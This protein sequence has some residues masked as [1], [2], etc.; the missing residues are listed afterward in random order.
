MIMLLLPISG[1]II[2]SL[3]MLFIPLMSV[4]S[5]ESTEALNIF[6]I[7]FYSYYSYKLLKVRLDEDFYFFNLAS[8]LVF[9]VIPLLLLFISGLFRGFCPGSDGFVFYFVNTSTLLVLITSLLMIFR[10]CN[11]PPHTGTIILIGIFV[12]S[13][14]YN[15]F[16]LL[17]EPQ[18]RFCSMIWGYFSGPIYDEDVSPDAYLLLCKGLSL[19]LSA[20]LLLLS[21]KKR[22]LLKNILV[23]LLFFPTLI[24]VKEISKFESSRESISK[25]LGGR[26]RTPHFEIIYP[27]DQEWSR[28][29]TVIG[30]LHEYYYK[31]IITELKITEDIK[32]KSYIFRNEEE[33]KELTGA[34]RTQIAKPWLKEIYITPVSLTDARLKHEISHIISAILIDSPLGLYGKFRGIIPNM[35][36]VEG[37]AVA[38]EPETNILSLHQRAAVLFRENRLPSFSRLFDVRKFYSSSGPISYSAAGS[39][40][41]FLLD[42]YGIENFKR[43]LK[44]EDFRIIYKKDVSQIEK[45]YIEFIKKIDISP[46]ERYW[47]TLLYKSRGL[48]EKRCPH[49]IATFKRLLSESNRKGISTISSEVYKYLV[50]YCEEDN[51]IIS[52]LLKSIILRQDL[53]EAEQFIN[54][55]LP[56]VSDAYH[57][58]LLLDSYTD[59]LF[60]KNRISEAGLTINEYLKKIPDSDARRN[61]ELKKYVIDLQDY[62]LL[63]NFFSPERAPTSK[64]GILI[65]RIK[66]NKNPVAY[67]L[68]ARLLFNVKDYKNSAEYLRDFINLS[69]SQD[70]IPPSALIEAANMLLAIAIYTHNFELGE[71]ATQKVEEFINQNLDSFPYHAR[72]YFHL[73]EFLQYLKKESPLPDSP[74]NKNER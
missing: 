8:A 45:E 4:P 25:R 1:S 22:S 15:I 66:E 26:Y 34:G 46:Q 19:L 27:P 38:L 18:V 31:Q 30:H 16:L 51:D 69:S 28:E 10:R 7:L 72:R 61:F 21:Y 12:L 71:E 3:I 70:N 52:E 23:I 33:K 50:D 55:N 59:I 62:E 32:L 40:I 11:L 29:I 48:I 49:E 39:F 5:Y 35:A 63:R 42:N 9:F 47:A 73:K 54:K 43:L 44:H 58:T 14:S 74:S 53:E 17:S 2:F 6:I 64:A 41:R 57:Y 60:F 68:F 67:Y 56:I 24:M 13:L 20:M 65:K 36:V 37:I